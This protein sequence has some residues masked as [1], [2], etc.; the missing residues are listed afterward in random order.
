MKLC[1]K[2]IKNNKIDSVLLVISISII[3]LCDTDLPTR[4]FFILPIWR[5]FHNNR[6]YWL[7]STFMNKVG[8][9]R[10]TP[11]LHTPFH[12]RHNPSAPAFTTLNEFWNMWQK[13]I[14][15]SNWIFM[16]FYEEISFEVNYF[17][18]CADCF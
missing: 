6:I 3:T 5:L 7:K 2:Q 11:S 9:G 12:S 13:I 8:R 18:V 10:E 14:T 15:Y 4:I 17:V 1:D 16:N